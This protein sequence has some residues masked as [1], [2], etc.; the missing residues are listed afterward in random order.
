[1]GRERV[2]SLHVA[3]GYLKVDKNDSQTDQSLL[4]TLG[5]FPCKQP[6][7]HHDRV[8]FRTSRTGLVKSNTVF[9]MRGGV[10]ATEW[11]VYRSWDSLELD[12]G[13]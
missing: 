13:D 12:T 7:H 9:E 1:M 8:Y 10:Q 11:E 3:V 4:H 2:R 6:H 5:R